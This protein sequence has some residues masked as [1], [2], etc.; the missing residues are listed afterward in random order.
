MIMK[1]KIQPLHFSIAEDLEKFTVKKVNK[2]ITKHDDVVSVDVIMKVVKPETSN[3]KEVEIHI[4][5]PG[6]EIFAKKTADSFEEAV[7]ASLEAIKR[8]LEKQKEK[9]L[10]HK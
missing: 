8:Q 5:I 9:T 10:N 1:I 3:N 7:V 6:N 4:T 2:V